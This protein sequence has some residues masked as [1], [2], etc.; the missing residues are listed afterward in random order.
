MVVKCLWEGGRVSG[1]CPNL[2]DG[3]SNEGQAL[4]TL[5]SGSTQDIEG[6]MGG[7]EKGAW[8]ELT[9]RAAL[10]KQGHRYL[11]SMTK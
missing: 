11:S 5:I 8:Y 1:R 3:C 9:V 6:D 4:K 7:T 2:Q 10:G